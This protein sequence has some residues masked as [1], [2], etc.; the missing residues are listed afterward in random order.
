M[1]GLK[2]RPRLREVANTASPLDIHQ[3]FDIRAKYYAATIAPRKGVKLLSSNRSS[4]PFI[5][6]S[7]QETCNSIYM[8][9]V[10][11]KDYAD[12]INSVYKN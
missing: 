9:I 5:S 4:S 10:R 1:L 8:Y 11:Y 12:N 7:L 2:K 6:A 3:W